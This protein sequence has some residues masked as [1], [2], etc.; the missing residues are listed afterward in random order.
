MESTDSQQNLDHS[1]EE[2]AAAMLTDI[3]AR[4]LG[5]LMEKQ[6][7][8]PDAYPLTLNSLVLAC[9]QK[10]SREPQTNFSN[11]DVQ[12][13]LNGLRDRKLVEVEYGSRADRFGQRLTREL[14]L[15]KKVQAIITII[16]LRGL[17]TINELLSRTQRM[18]DFE[19][20]QQVEELLEHQCQKTSP[21]IRRIP[22]QVGQREDR[23]AHLLCGEP[24]IAALSVQPNKPSASVNH[25]LELRITKLE[26]QVAQLMA[27]NGLSEENK[28]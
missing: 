3:E 15:D 28:A 9:N 8:T 5:A 7:T 22:R 10:T 14:G 26:E 24:D 6:L 11:A 27:L 4:V 25:D 13:C 23:F 19:S 16:L 12:H 18:M 2:Q 20:S 21:I 17:Q 1:V